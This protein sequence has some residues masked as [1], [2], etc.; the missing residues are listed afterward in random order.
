MAVGFVAVF[1]GTTNIT[2]ACTIMGVEVFGA[3]AAVAVAILPVIA[4]GFS[5]HR[6]RYRTQRATLQESGGITKGHQRRHGRQQRRGDLAHRPQ[7]ARALANR[8][9][10]AG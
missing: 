9:D 2:T 8:T 4:V 7:P 3:A 10:A 5:A 6:G 1:A